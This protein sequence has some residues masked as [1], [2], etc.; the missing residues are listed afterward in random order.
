M[1]KIQLLLLHLIH[2]YLNIIILLPPLFPTRESISSIKIILG[3]IS[4]A[5]LNKHLINYSDSPTYLDIR[6]EELIEKKVQSHS[7]AQ[8]LAK[9]VFPVP[10][11]I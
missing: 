4:L 3:F 11:L 8:A 7:E 6:S 10:F 5:F 1:P 2:Y 9:Y